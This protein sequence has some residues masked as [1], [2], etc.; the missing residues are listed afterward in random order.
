MRAFPTAGKKDLLVICPGFS[1]D[2]LET[3]EE[4]KVENQ[5]AFLAAGGDAFQYVKALNATQDHVALM[6]A[7]VEE[8]LFDRELRGRTPPRVNLNQF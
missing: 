7:L 3:I 5:D 8:H 2:C 1:V 4:I 6:V